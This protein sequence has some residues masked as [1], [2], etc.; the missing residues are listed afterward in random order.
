MASR[1]DHQ[2]QIEGPN[3]VFINIDQ[4]EESKN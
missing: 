1:G 4:Q 3:F 2:F